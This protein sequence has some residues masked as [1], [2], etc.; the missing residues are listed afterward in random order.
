MKQDTKV[1]LAFAFLASAA[2]SPAFAQ[3]LNIGAGMDFTAAVPT[4]VGWATILAGG[5][6]VVFS[7]VNGARAILDHRSIGPSAI[8]L[9]AGIIIA[10]GGPWAINKLAGNAV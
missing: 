9:I 4:I 3:G 2:V 10:F 6:M 5:A 1:I 8:G 7:L